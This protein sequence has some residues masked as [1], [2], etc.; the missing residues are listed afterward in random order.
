MRTRFTM[1][2]AAVAL[3]AALVLSACGSSGGGGTA[4]Q[5]S[6]TTSTTTASTTPSG[7]ATT[8]TTTA[9]VSGPRACVASGL[10]VAFVGQQGAT[11][12]GLLG[13]SLRNRGSARCHTY[14][15]PGVLFLDKAGRPLPTKSVR[16]THDFF[17]PAPKVRIVLAPGARASFRLGVTHGVTSTAQ[18]ATAYGLQVIPPDDTATLRAKIPGGAYECRTTTVSPLRPGRSAYP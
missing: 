1:P 11:G 3:S 16:T 13:F 7:T 12:H 15:Y 14:G 9:T 10:A 5:A 17:G 6:S 8:T 4:S 2:A 18:C